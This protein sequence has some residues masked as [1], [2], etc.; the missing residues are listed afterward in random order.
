MR[1]L[2]FV[3]ALFVSTLALAQPKINFVK[4]AHDFGEVPEGK[5]AS[6]DYEFVNT[7]NQPLIVSHVQA[8]CGCTTPFWTKEP[9]LPGKKGIVKASY[10]SQGRPGAFSKSVT[11][12][13]NAA[14]GAKTLTFKGNVLAKGDKPT[15]T[16]EMKANSAKI[17]YDKMEVNLGRLETGQSAVARFQVTNKG[18]SKL[19]ILDAQAGFGNTWTFSKSNLEPNETGTL[20]INYRAPSKAGDATETVTVTSTDYNDYFTKLT[21]KAKVVESKAQPSV[22]KPGANAV[23]FK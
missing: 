22:L 4:E 5:I 3:A 1:L 8:S 13:S 18:K 14:E 2:S 17:V 12:T 10:N 19:E 7:G 20:E 6:F 21:L 15:I 9:V 11:V 16:D 23:P